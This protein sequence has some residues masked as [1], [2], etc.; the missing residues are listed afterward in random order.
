MLWS[1]SCTATEEVA[2]CESASQA[3]FSEEIA[4]LSEDMLLAVTEDAPSTDIA[5]SSI[6]EGVSLVDAFVQTGLAKSRGEARR[7]VQGRGAYVNNVQQSDVARVLGTDDL[8]HDR[9]IVVR[10]GRHDVHVLR[11]ATE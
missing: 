2:K 7:T 1:L 6:T 3:L 8:L 4:A 9:Y 10:K 11:A 5:R